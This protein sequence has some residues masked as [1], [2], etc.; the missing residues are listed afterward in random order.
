M[1]T[2]VDA[3]GLPCPQ[4]VILTRQAMSTADQVLTLVSERDQVDNVL[5]LAE[6]A[7]WQTHWEPQA[8][9]YAIHLVKGEAT[10]QPELTP[11]LLTSNPPAE[12]SVVVL[13]S[14][15]MGRGNDELGEILVRS[16]LYTLTQ[17]EPRPKTLVLYN[18]GVRLAV[19]GSPVLDEL[20]KLAADGVEI[21]VCGTCL[22]YFELKERLAV[23]T[24]SNMYSIA[25][26]LL[27][28]NRV[29]TV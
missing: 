19:E 15:R 27:T 24:L 3:R 7:G 29:I 4:P 11:D 6:R 17:V 1:P 9:G 8:D 28:A 20:Q 25:E 14:E 10:R 2:T 16:F 22:G 13:A 26:A 18:T 5:R 21:L 23:G 12:G